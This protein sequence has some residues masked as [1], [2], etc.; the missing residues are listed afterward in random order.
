MEKSVFSQTLAL[1]GLLRISGG[2]CH[3]LSNHTI[4]KIE[5]LGDIGG[6]TSRNRVVLYIAVVAI[7]T[8]DASNGTFIELKWTDRFIIL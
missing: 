8:D 1:L 7:H 3:N 5:F 4:V 6:I 2:H